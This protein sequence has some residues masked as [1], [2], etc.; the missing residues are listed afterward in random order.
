MV[1]GLSVYTAA[2]SLDTVR[3]GCR[4][5]S[6]CPVHGSWRSLE[7]QLVS[8]AALH[9]V[10]FCIRNKPFFTVMHPAPIQV[11]RA[12]INATPWSITHSTQHRP[13]ACIRDT[14]CAV[15]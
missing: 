5:P 4:R 2:T 8:S 11:R 6:G 12:F 10:V 1:E 15:K 3:E 9:G 14:I 13:C 7:V